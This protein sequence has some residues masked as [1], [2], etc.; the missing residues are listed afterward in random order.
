MDYMLIPKLYTAFFIFLMGIC[1]G[2]FLNVLIYRIP[3]KENFTTTNS[4]CMS[5][6]HR[7]Y[8]KDLVPLF[9][10]LFLGGNCRYCKAKISPQYPIVEALN[11]IMYVLVFWFVTDCQLNLAMVGY[12]L[13]ISALIV[14]SAIDIKIMEIP[15]SMWVTI[16]IGG[17]LVY[18][19]DLIANGFIFENLIERVIGFFAAST[20]LFVLAVITKGGMG[21][22]DIKL[23]AACGFLLGWQLVLLSLIFGALLGTVYFVIVYIKNKKKEEKLDHKVPFAPHLALAVAICIFVGQQFLDWYLLVCGITGGHDHHHHVH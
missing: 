14:A 13:A 16:L 12:C 10:W 17:I 21:G 7:L 11:G 4:H 1:I 2:S 15:D 23:M 6:N 3:K 18:V 22:G 9:S 19:N 20:I 8:A 5:C